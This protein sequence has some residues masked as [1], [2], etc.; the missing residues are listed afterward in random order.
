MHHLPNEFRRQ[1]KTA[2]LPPRKSSLPARYSCPFTAEE[3]HSHHQRDFAR[4]GNP[5]CAMVTAGIEQ[6][7]RDHDYLFIVSS[8]HNDKPLLQKT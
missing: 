5:Y 3:A 8:H 1:P 7:L 4:V 2:S 6:Y